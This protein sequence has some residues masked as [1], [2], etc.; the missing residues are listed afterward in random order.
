M[1]MKCMSFIHAFIHSE[2]IE[3]NQLPL[4]H[5]RHRYL[6]TKFYFRFL[7]CS[8]AGWDLLLVICMCMRARGSLIHPWSLSRSLV[9]I[10][11]EIL[12]FVF[13]FEAPFLLNNNSLGSDSTF[14]FSRPWCL[15]NSLMCAWV[16]FDSNAPVWLSKQVTNWL[17]CLFDLI[18]NEPNQFKWKPKRFY[19][20]F[21]SSFVMCVPG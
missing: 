14:S 9:L 8:S 11:T 21:I 3:W 5:F 10:W 17:R 19:P 16:C 20:T 1:P 12:P 18:T 6:S 7:L 2:W 15:L 4:M 13:I